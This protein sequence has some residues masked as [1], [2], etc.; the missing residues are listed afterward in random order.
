MEKEKID[1]INHLARKHREHGLTDEEK[2]E[3]EALR[4]EYREGFKMGLAQHLDNVYYKMPDG[5]L[6]KAVKGEVKIPGVNTEG[7]K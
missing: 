6:V 1:R 4:N 3:Q 2:A 5:S 7:K